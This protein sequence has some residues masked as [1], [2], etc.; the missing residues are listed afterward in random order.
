[1]SIPSDSALAPRIGGRGWLW[2]GLAVGVLGV[3]AYVRQVAALR[4]GMPWYL[5]F[6]GTL[7]VIL[8]VRSLWEARSAWRY[9]ALVFVLLLTGME[10]MFVLS[11][12][13]PSYA[14]P[15]AVGKPFPV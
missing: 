11:T 6:T 12:R 2:L 13:L 9:L 10:W 3:L 1:M 4:L 5:P 8:V 15:V 7:A 14:G